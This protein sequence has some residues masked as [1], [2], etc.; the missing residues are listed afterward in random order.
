MLYRFFELS[1][2][3]NV[4]DRNYFNDEP[5]KIKTSDIQKVSL[6][7]ND[8]GKLVI[9]LFSELSS[10]KDGL[11]I[12]AVLEDY[13]NV[14]IDGLED[15]TS[16]NKKQL[17]YF[18]TS[19]KDADQEKYTEKSYRVFKVTLDKAQE[20]LND[21][22]SDINTYIQMLSVLKNSYSELELKTSS[23]YEDVE[24]KIKTFLN[25]N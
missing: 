1:N 14:T 3:Q 20:I 23:F 9:S 15:L 19:I 25:E 11:I 16:A 10:G 5:S 21:Q 6:T 7:K 2:Y 4:A 12:R 8:E 24:S 13:Q 22:T 18:Y 17:Q